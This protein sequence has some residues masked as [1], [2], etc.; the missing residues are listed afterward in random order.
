LRK[1]DHVREGARHVASFRRNVP[2]GAERR[3]N[4]TRC[5]RT[6][7]ISGSSTPDMLPLLAP[8]TIPHYTA[9]RRNTLSEDARQRAAPCGTAEPQRNASGAN[10]ALR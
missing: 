1:F 3:R 9:S 2:R 7:L 8:C 5:E 10:A 6:S 4:Q